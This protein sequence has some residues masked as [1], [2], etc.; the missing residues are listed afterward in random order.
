M[1]FGLA[2]L[3]STPNDIRSLFRMLSKQREKEKET[4]IVLVFAFCFGAQYRL[5]PVDNSPT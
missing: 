3:A 2:A 4:N 5:M 1:L